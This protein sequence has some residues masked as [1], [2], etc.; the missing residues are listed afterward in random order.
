LFY[1]GC[2]VTAG[3]WFGGFYSHS[4]F[5]LS[6]AEARN[7]VNWDIYINIAAVRIGQALINS[8][9]LMRSPTF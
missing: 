6:E 2:G 8:V 9:L 1:G 3:V 7:A 4:R 5:F